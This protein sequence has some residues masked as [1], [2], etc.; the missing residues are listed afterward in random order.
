MIM[1]A[2]VTM[3]EESSLN[4][5]MSQP[6]TNPQALATRRQRITAGTMGSPALYATAMTT[7]ESATVEPTEMSMF[8]RM[9][10]MVMGST[11]NAMSRNVMGVWRNV[12]RLK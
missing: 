3:T 9:M 4:L 8:P 12:S 7:A 11:R 1:V 10:T 2:S 6:F 5:V